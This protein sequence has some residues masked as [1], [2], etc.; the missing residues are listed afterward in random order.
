MVGFIRLSQ[1][2]H[3]LQY[4]HMDLL[5]PVIPDLLSNSPLSISYS[6]NNL[7]LTTSPPDS[8]SHLDYRHLTD[9]SRTDLSFHQVKT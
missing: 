7:P 6:N 8:N 3:Q 9:N 5:V 1:F 4:H 2:H